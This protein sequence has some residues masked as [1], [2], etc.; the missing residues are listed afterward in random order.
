MLNFG[1]TRTTPRSVRSMS[2][3]GKVS[4][5]LLMSFVFNFFFSVWIIGVNLLNLKF[6]S[7]ELVA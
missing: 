1:R 2:I 6:E 7:I 3:G 4:I 5:H